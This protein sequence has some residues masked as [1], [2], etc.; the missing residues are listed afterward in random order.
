M[1]VLATGVVFT[2]LVLNRLALRAWS[3]GAL[4][5]WTAGQGVEIMLCRSLTRLPW[6][7]TRHAFR[8]LVR[9]PHGRYRN[10]RARI[11]PWRREPG[12][13]VDVTWDDA[14]RAR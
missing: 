14:R 4:E 3:R 12:R 13:R 5:R 6:P 2:G 11:T 1:V 9:D 8:I 7:F 10:A